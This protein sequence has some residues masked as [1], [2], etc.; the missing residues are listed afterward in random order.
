MRLRSPAS[1]A[2]AI[3]VVAVT[4]LYVVTR[5]RQ[6]PGPA[7]PLVV[8]STTG[9][10]VDRYGRW[11]LTLAY[12]TGQVENPWEDVR[13]DATFAT[14]SNRRIQAR[15][16]YYERDRYKLRF[17]AAEVGTY[18]YS[19]TVGGPAGR[20]AG[21]GSF[22]SVPSDNRG[23]VRVSEDNP[24]RL[25]FDD[26]SAFNA[27]GINECLDDN[28][29]NGKL[30]EIQMDGGL[31]A[32][33]Q[34][35]DP[36]APVV[37]IGTYLQAYGAAGA[38]FNLFRWNPDNCGFAIAERISLDGNRYFERQGKLGD[39]LL[40]TARREGFRVLFTLFFK[41]PYPT[42][43][44]R[45]REA[46][47]VKRY[48]DY[49]M[50][51][52]GADVDIWELTNETVAP[53]A[54]GA[55]HAPAGDADPQHAA[56]PAADRG[57]GREADPSPDHDE[58]AAAPTSDQVPDGW[59]RMA[60]AHLRANDAYKRMVTNS[61]PRPIDATLFDARSP[62][63]YET[64][65]AV[66]S[67]LSTTRQIDD[68]GEGLPIIFGEQGNMGLN[69]DPGS[70]VRLRI[71]S[72]TAFFEQSVLLFWNLSFAKD[73]P[74]LG[75]YLGPQE[76]GYIRALQ[77]FTAGTAGNLR[78]IDMPVDGAG[79]RAYGLASSDTVAGYLQ[80][81]ADHGSSTTAAV[82]V[83]VP[84]DGVARWVEPSTGKVLVTQAVNQGRQRLVSPSFDVDTALR[85][86]RQ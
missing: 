76:R 20:V 19:V 32:E 72:W 82:E 21:T 7:G 23:F 18:T 12:S 57:A 70:A 65:P 31:R 29:E 53:P 1:V 86:S 59:L 14:P 33:G 17:A 63:W 71:R 52:W 79:V 30:D 22:R 41:A 67:D 43:A 47:A 35:T 24:Y 42:A 73:C 26:G 77:D 84:F 85:I 38:G 39:D 62:H 66:E 68:A 55:D 46:D 9:P 16:F 8:E 25:N 34:E 74:C 40:E 51:R 56:A 81:F 54:D 27:I 50:A 60:A 83:D 61:Y 4:S 48:I 80:H 45:P 49:V 2:L 44:D 3:V 37:D 5:S 69:W 10:V 78:P 58:D 11:E 64:E 6:D 75:V 36:G 28:D 13:V 15:G